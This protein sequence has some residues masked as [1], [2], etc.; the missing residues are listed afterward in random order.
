VSGVNADSPAMPAGVLGEMKL[1]NITCGPSSHPAT[2][3]APFITFLAI[4]GLTEMLSPAF[5]CQDP[6]PIR[7][8]RLVTHMLTMSTLKIGHPITIFI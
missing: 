3:T 4:Q 8:R 2:S 5:L 6:G 7:H 1:I